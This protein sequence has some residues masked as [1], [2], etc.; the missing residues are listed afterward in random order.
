MGFTRCLFSRVLSLRWMVLR[1]C[2]TEQ[3]TQAPMFIVKTLP[4]RLSGYR[5]ED[6]G[7]I[8]RHQHAARM[9]SSGESAQNLLK[10][11]QRG[12]ATT[13]LAHMMVVYVHGMDVCWLPQLK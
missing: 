4:R 5:G 11:Q 8:E 3:T 9:Y 6:C 10:K 12:G 13:P 7:T 2:R 1:S